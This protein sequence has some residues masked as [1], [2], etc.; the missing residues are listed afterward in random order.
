MSDENSQ[1]EAFY[2]KAADIANKHLVMALEEG[3]AL[4]NLVGLM[5]IE[6]AVNA[7]ADATSREDV[8]RLLK[9]L[10]VQ[11]EQDIKENP[12]DD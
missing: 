6:V 12:E 8:V 11:I 2:E 9:D 10:V 3:D 4:G 5:M 1:M 7:F